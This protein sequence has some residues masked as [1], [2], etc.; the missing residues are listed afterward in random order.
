VIHECVLCGAEIREG[1]YYYKLDGIPY[2]E[3]CVE[4]GREEAESSWN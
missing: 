1:D 4:D 3:E 2:C